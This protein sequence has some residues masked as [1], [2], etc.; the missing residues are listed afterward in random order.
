[1]QVQA[2]AHRLWNEPGSLFLITIYPGL[3]QVLDGR[4]DCCIQCRAVTDDFGNLRV[5]TGW[6]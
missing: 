5:V 1:M 2:N 6:R 3:V 4:E